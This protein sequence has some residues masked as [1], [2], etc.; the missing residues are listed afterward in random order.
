MDKIIL[1]IKIAPSN[2]HKE[3]AMEKF[4]LSLKNKKLLA[5]LATR[6]LYVLHQ[7]EYTVLKV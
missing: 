7:N 3:D 4:L 1:F 2:T 6:R 5:T